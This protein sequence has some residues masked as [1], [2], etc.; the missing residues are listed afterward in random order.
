MAKGP[1]V[2]AATMIL[3][4]GFLNFRRS[5]RYAARYGHACGALGRPPNLEEYRLFH[6]MSLSQA[7]REQAA[8][9]ACVGDL[10]IYDLVNKDAWADKGFTEQQ[11]EDAVARWL[12]GRDV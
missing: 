7:Y 11:R 10:L 9:R 5:V 3:A 12:A 1:K 6:G 2:T 8:W 4:G